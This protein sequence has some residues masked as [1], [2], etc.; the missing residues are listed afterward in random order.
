MKTV[1]FFSRQ[2]RGVEF[3]YA[4]SELEYLALVEAVCHYL[5]IFMDEILL[6]QTDHRALEHY[7]SLWKTC[8]V[9]TLLTDSSNDDPL[10]M[11]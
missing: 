6:L 8:S 7:Y 1:A 11:R 2:L 4:A 5:C 3:N 10:Q 9:G